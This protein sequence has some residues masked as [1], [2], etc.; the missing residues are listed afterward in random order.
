M[1]LVL[2]G[3]GP[4]V[5]T[6]PPVSDKPAEALELT[7]IYLTPHTISLYDGVNWVDEPVSDCLSLVHKD[8]DVLSFRFQ[9][10]QTN[11]HLCYMEGQAV[12]EDERWVYRETLD[13]GSPCE[14]RI[15]VS[16]K[17]IALEDVEDHCRAYYCG[18]RAYIFASFPRPPSAEPHSADC[19]VP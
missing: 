14:L 5:A 6:R 17:V 1:A 4:A 2:A 12:L 18:A 9:L 19:G 11:A 3:C 13:D 10:V 7:G 15:D 16:D 8:E